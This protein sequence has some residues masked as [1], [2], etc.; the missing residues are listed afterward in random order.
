MHSTVVRDSISHSLHNGG[1]VQQQ[2]FSFYNTPV[3]SLTTRGKR[4]RL[5]LEVLIGTAFFGGLT[6]YMYLRWWKKQQI[7][8]YTEG[9]VYLKWPKAKALRWEQIETIGYELKN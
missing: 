3:P 5:G 8:L 1:N 9:F 4:D 2:R 7:H 6:L